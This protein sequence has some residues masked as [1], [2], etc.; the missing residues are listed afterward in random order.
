MA[1]AYCTLFLKSPHSLSNR[2]F[3][4]RDQVIMSFHTHCLYSGLLLCLHV[5]VF[6]NRWTEDA[7]KYKELAAMFQI[8]ALHFLCFVTLSEEAKFSKSHGL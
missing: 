7:V 1:E 6:D 2:L 5:V 4:A 8:Q 3:H